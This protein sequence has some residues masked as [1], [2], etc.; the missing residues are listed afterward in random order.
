MMKHKMTFFVLAVAGLILSCYLCGCGQKPAKTEGPKKPEI[1]IW[2]WMSDRDDAF[3]ELA[4]RYEEKFGVKVDFQLFAPS[5]AYS[6]KVRA[7]AQTNTLPD[8]YGILAETRDFASFV[9][10][11]FVEEIT[12]YMEE[13]EAAWKNSFF[14]KALLMDTFVE[15]NQFGVKPGIYGVP[16]DVTNIQFLYNKDLFAEAGLDPENPP[17]TFV[18]FIEAG[19]KLK[20]KGIQGVVSGWGEIWMINCLADNFAWN[21]MGKDKVMATIKGE[22]QYTDPDWVAVFSLFKEMGESG[23]LASGMITMVNKHAE[24][25]FANGRA[26]MAFNGSWCVNVYKGMNP[27]LRYATFLPPRVSKDN[28]VVVWGGAGSSFKINARSL[29]KEKAVD[30]LKWITAPEQQIFLAKETLNLPA[31]TDSLMGIPPVMRQ[32]AESMQYAVHPSQLPC[33]EFPRIAETMGKGIQLIIIG[34]KTPEQLAQELARVKAEQ[35]ERANQ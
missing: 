6:N 2:H 32:F 22:V 7:S 13:N 8:V 28:P 18:E 31:N 23:M 21:I 24:Q 15:G 1:V 12:P 11:G 30:F 20:A 14:K 3:Q 35:M 27:D 19:K 10:A 29:N 17:Q 4:R 25:M 9:K 5:E 16:I 26:A 33:V 34:K